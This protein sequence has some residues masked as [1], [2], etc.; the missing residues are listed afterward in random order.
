M[1]RKWELKRITHWDFYKTKVTVVG[2]GCRQ[3]TGNGSVR[4]SSFP[5]DNVWTWRTQWW[6]REGQ[7]WDLLFPSSGDLSLPIPSVM[8]WLMAPLEQSPALTSLFIVHFLLSIF[9]NNLETLKVHPFNDFNQT[10]LLLARKVKE[11]KYNWEFIP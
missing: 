3:W 11:A 1:I 8:I 4:S 2:N 5:R 9:C 10:L 7:C 6:S